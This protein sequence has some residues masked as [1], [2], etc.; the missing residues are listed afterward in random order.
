MLNICKKKYII[1]LKFKDLSVFFT[2]KIVKTIIK[3]KQSAVCGHSNARG[4]EDCWALLKQVTLNYENLPNKTQ[5]D[6][7]NMS[8]PIYTFPVKFLLSL[9]INCVF[10]KLSACFLN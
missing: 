10:S 1:Q 8:L 4:T 3:Y 2:F 7:E 9:F 5:C 6:W